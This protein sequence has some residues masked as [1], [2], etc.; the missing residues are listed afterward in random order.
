[1]EISNPASASTDTVI[2]VGC[3]ES[4][5]VLGQVLLPSLANLA[6]SSS[7]SVDGGAANGDAL[8]HLT[9]GLQA[10]LQ[11]LERAVSA[12]LQCCTVVSGCTCH[13]C[14]K[15]YP[16]A[17]D[18]PTIQRLASPKSHRRC[19]AVCIFLPHSAV[20]SHATRIGTPHCSLQAPGTSAALLQ[21][22]LVKLATS[23]DPSLGPSKAAAASLLGRAP[24]SGSGGVYGSREGGVQ[25]RRAVLF[26]LGDKWR[27][28]GWGGGWLMGI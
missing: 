21:E 1:M 23:G 2:P 4:A 10:Q 5:A 14:P 26:G 27:R 24:P 15:A 3:S 13:H 12:T 20:I 8:G 11:Q 25:V 6:R 22:L 18:A 7:G 17:A 28:A 9:A 19:V 16:E